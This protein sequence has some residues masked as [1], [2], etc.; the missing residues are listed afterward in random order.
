MKKLSI[1]VIII[2]ASVVFTFAQ[3][4][5]APS[6][7]LNQPLTGNQHYKASK[8]IDMTVAPGSTIGFQYNA[9]NSNGEFMAEIDPF[10]VFPP[11][12]GET[13]GPIGAGGI[14]GEDGVVGAIEGDLSISELGS[15]VYSIPIN[16]PLST[17]GMTPILTLNYNSNGGWGLGGQGWDIGGIS[18]IMFTTP[19]MYYDG[20]TFALMGGE[21]N[22]D[23]ML[24]DGERLIQVS[25]KE[26]PSEKTNRS[27]RAYFA[28]YRK[29]N[30]DF[31][32]ITFEL[33]GDGSVFCI[34]KT[35]GGMIY[36]YGG[37]ISNST[38]VHRK[39]T[40]HGTAIYGYYIKT[41]EDNY[42]NIIE[43]DYYNDPATGT[44]I[45]STVKYGKNK[46]YSS[47]FDY[48]ITFNYS[49]TGKELKSYNYYLNSEAHI[50][51]KHKL[52]FITCKHLKTD[53]DVRKYVLNYQYT[54]DDITSHKYYYINSIEEF[55]LGDIK[56]NK[57][58]FEF[59]NNQS[60]NNPAFHSNIYTTS[61][62]KFVS[63]QQGNFTGNLNQELLIETSEHGN[64]DTIFYTIYKDNSIAMPIVKVLNR[65]PFACLA[66]DYDGDGKTDFISVVIDKDK[67]DNIKKYYILYFKSGGSSF[68]Q[69]QIIKEINV[70]THYIIDCFQGDFNGDGI[71]DFAYRQNNGR[72]HFFTGS[73]GW[74]HGNLGN[75][76]ISLFINPEYSVITGNFR[77]F[78]RTD[79]FIYKETTLFNGLIIQDRKIMYLNYTAASGFREEYIDVNLHESDDSQDFVAGDF[80]GDGKTDLVSC[81]MDKKE[82]LLSFR[83]YHSFGAGF[84]FKNSKVIRDFMEEDFL[85]S[86]SLFPAN[87]DGNNSTDIF[88]RIG[89]RKYPFPIGNE[90]RPL[91]DNSHYGILC[92]FNYTGDNFIYKPFI[93]PQTN[94]LSILDQN[95]SFGIND[96]NSDGAS[97]IYVNK[98]NQKRFATYSCK[99]EKRSITKITNG[100]GF[101]Y[102]IEYSNSTDQSVYTPGIY[103]TF[104]VGQLSFPLKLVKGLK[105]S[106]GIGGLSSTEY[107]YTSGLI[108]KQGRGFLGFEKNTTKNIEN[109]LTTI[110][111]RI[112]NTEYFILLSKFQ[113]S[114]IG[115]K[116]IGHTKLTYNF[117][118]WGRKNYFVYLEESLNKNY[119]LDGNLTSVS[120]T[121]SYKIENGARIDYDDYGNSL[122]TITETGLAEN[123]LNYKT[124]VRSYYNNYTSNNNWVLGRLTTS[125]S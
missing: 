1:T 113:I 80:N 23:C 37:N 97:D 88:I 30:D 54:G 86:F 117:K 7:I 81:K 60:W 51:L 77:N 100:V 109:S 95:D 21:F 22:S 74:D 26:N 112:L 13:G 24:L 104:P 98:Y 79:F 107:Y 17:G 82:K 5:Q 43:F 69:P 8:F 72:L 14:V 94:A 119:E 111:E 58:V 10:M 67:D 75:L 66:A 55:G 9:N 64:K 42:G 90:P 27:N 2:A 105:T 125:Y 62:Q 92:Y 48:E 3:T 6:F 12:E 85:N 18:T 96:I 38:A 116:V 84:V 56:Y 78:N 25:V 28:E 115:A 121:R 52:D 33:P 61:S 99:L 35:K 73:S 68:L 57:T 124:W 46:N 110:N 102:L 103:N 36:T 87:F 15:L 106:N 19:N 65:H 83:I 45:P 47:N 11:E 63:E 29:E 123:S 108:H 93:D 101:Q 32:K 4:Q 39:N 20:E 71:V 114:K 50:S 34:V 91:R 120:R 76:S 31:S 44:I 16:I 59:E 89:K 40:E 49:K 41:I 70:T 122:F 118:N 53:T